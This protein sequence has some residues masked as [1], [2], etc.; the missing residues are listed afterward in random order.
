MW[1]QP[2]FIIGFS[3]LAIFL[4]GSFAYEWIFGNVPRQLFFIKENGHVVEGLPISPKWAFPFGTDQFGYD[5]LGK[6]IIGA[7]FTI[8]AA[9][10]IAALRMLIAIPLGFILSTYLRRHQTWISGLIDSLHYI[11]LTLFAYFVL[12]PVLW[13]PED[14]F[15]TGMWERIAIQIVIMAFLTMPIVSVL[16]ANESALLYDKEYVLASRTLGAG[17]FRIIWR[18]LFPQMRE[19]LAVLYGQQVI[20]TF[21][22]LAHLGL[23]NLFLG[24]TKVS[25]DPLFGDPPMSIAYEWAGLFGSTFRY[26]LGAPWLPLT[27]VLFISISI[28][29]VSFMIEG[30]VRSKNPK[31][32]KSSNAK[33][34]SR[35]VAWNKEQL[36]EKMVLL[37]ASDNTLKK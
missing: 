34:K 31:V 19:K 20:E 35:V 27:S 5:M 30:Y 36:R 37:K 15:S 25:Y 9:L 22:I 21:V 24:G 18:H 10:A 16:I 12:I 33:E 23:L 8:I 6:I 13:M 17:R 26:L 3:I 7:K 1:K 2:I 11:P 32:K 4:F 28:L 14:G 29:S